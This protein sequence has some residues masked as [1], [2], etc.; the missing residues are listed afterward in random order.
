M[1]A[2]MLDGAY[3]CEP[4]KALFFLG[5][6]LHIFAFGFSN[7]SLVTGH[8]SMSHIA[9]RTTQSIALAVMPWRTRM[10]AAMLDGAYL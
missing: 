8:N 4:T 1:H 5:F 7:T 10:H 2:A 9:V 3:L 6:V